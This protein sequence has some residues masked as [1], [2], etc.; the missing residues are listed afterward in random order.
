MI[1]VNDLYLKNFSPWTVMGRTNCIR[2]VKFT[3]I[4]AKIIRN[5]EAISQLFMKEQLTLTR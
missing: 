2:Y 4:R 3:F 1:A 5:L